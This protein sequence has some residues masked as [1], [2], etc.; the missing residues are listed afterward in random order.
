MTARICIG[1]SLLGMLV[2]ACWPAPEPKDKPIEERAFG[3]SVAQ[4]SSAGTAGA[5]TVLEIAINR[6]PSGYQAQWAMTQAGCAHN[7]AASEQ[8][9]SLQGRLAKFPESV[10]T[11]VQGKRVTS[12]TMEAEF[13]FVGEGEKWTRSMRFEMSPDRQKLTRTELADGQRTQYT[14]CPKFGSVLVKST[15]EV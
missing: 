11:M 14:R 8:I 12:R 7:K 15:F 5:E 9:M 2:G 1:A 3:P 13:E 4:A 6:F 10:G